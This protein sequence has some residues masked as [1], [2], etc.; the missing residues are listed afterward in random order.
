MQ[1]VIK[2]HSC[3]YTI[4]LK[5]TQNTTSKIIQEKRGGKK[6]T[7]VS[8]P[9]DMLQRYILLKPNTDT[10]NFLLRKN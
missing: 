6:P 7:N 1:R 8:A 10:T 4:A 3:V 9:L 5:I 2:Y